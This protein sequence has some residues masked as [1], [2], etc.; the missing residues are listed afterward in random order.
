MRALRLLWKRP[1]K[2][3]GSELYEDFISRIPV[4]C[5]RPKI[6]FD[7]F[8]TIHVHSLCYM[9]VFPWM[10]E[11][12][13]NQNFVEKNELHSL[14]LVLTKRMAFQMNYETLFCFVLFTVYGIP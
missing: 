2:T 3:F 8:V 12:L 6:Y 11:R 10:G 5:S 7:V 9:Y 4:T 1:F 13:R 14:D